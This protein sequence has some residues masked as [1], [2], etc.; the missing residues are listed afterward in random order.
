MPWLMVAGKKHV[1]VERQDDWD[2]EWGDYYFEAVKFRNGDSDYDLRAVSTSG[3][4]MGRNVKYYPPL[5]ASP[6]WLCD[7]GV[8]DLIEELEPGIHQFL[9]FEIRSGKRGE[10]ACTRHIIQIREPL[11][12]VDVEN[13]DPLAVK[14][15]NYDNGNVGMLIKTLAM[16]VAKAKLAVNKNIIGSRHLWL[17]DRG[18]QYDKAFV[19]DELKT[20]LEAIIDMK[21]ITFYRLH[22]GG[23]NS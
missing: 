22:D 1:G 20:R 11:L 9:P 21:F 16:D 19:S 5:I 8:R 2:P 17:E 15:K 14:V 13:T 18:R 6:Y 23:S 10:V 4:F 12:A 3:W 7:D